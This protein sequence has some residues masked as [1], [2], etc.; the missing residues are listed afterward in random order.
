MASGNVQFPEK[1]EAIRK[2]IFTV[3]REVISCPLFFMPDGVCS[4]DWK[5][6]SVISAF[7]VSFD[8]SG[9]DA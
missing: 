6:W 7:N 4:K 8:V 5:S 2:R 1:R 9:I 3:G